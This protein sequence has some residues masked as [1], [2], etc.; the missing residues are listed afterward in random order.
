MIG[1]VRAL[2]LE[3]VSKGVTVNAV[4]PGYT[5]TDMLEQSLR[6]IAA[7]TANSRRKRRPAAMLQG[8]PLGRLIK[9][10]KWR[11]RWCFVLDGAAAITGTTVAIAGGALAVRDTASTPLDAETKVAERPADHHLE[12]R[13]WLRLLTG[14]P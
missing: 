9:P 2:A 13:P 14:R 1:L 12:L 6:T 11:P 10:T 5:D 7:K 4:C 3:T 8:C